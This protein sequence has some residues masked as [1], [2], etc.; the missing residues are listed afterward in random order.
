MGI[1]MDIQKL[2]EEAAELFNCNSEEVTIVHVSKT[3]PKCDHVWDNDGIEP[4]RCLKCGT[5]FISYVFRC[6]P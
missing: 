2:K 3:P 1:D 6:M 5:T 4:E